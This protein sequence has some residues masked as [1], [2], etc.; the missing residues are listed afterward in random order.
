MLWITRGIRRN[1]AAVVSGLGAIFLAFSATA[2]PF[3]SGWTLQPQNSVLSFQT[4]KNQS[5]VELSSFLDYTGAVDDTGQAEVRIR[6]ASV[7]TNVDLRNVRMRFLLF[8]TFNHPEATIALSVPEDVIADLPEKRRKRITLPFDLTLVGQTLTMETEMVVTLI[9]ANTVSVAAA[10]PISV[11]TDAFGLSD[12]IR[13]LEEAAEVSIVPSATVSF[14]FAF[15][16]NVP[17]ADEPVIATLVNASAPA[18]V[19]EAPLTLT[20]CAT[21]FEA[22]SRAGSIRFASGSDQL[23]DESLPVLD[24]L[25]SVVQRCP[26]LRLQVAGH[27]DS[28]GDPAN[29]LALSQQRAVTVARSLLDMGFPASNL[30]VV[31]Y[32]DTQPIATNNTEWGRQSNRRIEFSIL[33]SG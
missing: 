22:L 32:G 25:S 11:S 18:V 16:R 27:T 26:A 17:V 12:G 28:M 2:N 20:E 21:R 30:S 24:T 7:E 4:I 31:G 9:D 33:S 3:E 5:K 14:N 6:M 10:Y 23:N 13:R 15:G 8:E 1:S 29:N 19:E